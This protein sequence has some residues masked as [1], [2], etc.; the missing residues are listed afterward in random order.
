M[1]DLGDLTGREHL[2]YSSLTSWLDCGERFRL[3]RVLN[4]PQQ[5]AW[6]FIGGDVIHKSTETCDIEDVTDP[7]AAADIF[8]AAWE[9]ATKDLDPK[10]VLKAGGR[11][12]KEWPDK[13]N[14]DWWKANGAK[15]VTD[16][17]GWRVNKKAE[18]WQ[19]L[20]LEHEGHSYRGIEVPIEFTYKADSG[21]EVDVKGYIDRVMVDPQGQVWVIDLKSGGRVPASSLQL[22]IYSLGLAEVYGVHA[23]LGAYYMTRQGD[24]A[25][26]QSL[27]HYSRHV[28]GGWFSMAKKGIESE[29]FIPKVGMFCNSCSVRQ[30]CTAVGGDPSPLTTLAE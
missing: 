6:W 21:S 14:G 27:S 8:Y 3:E 20:T 10:E 26:T 25:Q 19:F 7:K 2:S 23:P 9:M 28:V 22:G 1:P 18:G 11:A 12:S 29:V 5:K 30:F 4:A 16:W 15:M 17:V 24:I 13:E